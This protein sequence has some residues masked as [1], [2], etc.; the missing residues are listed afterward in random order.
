M[1]LRERYR[2]GLDP[3]LPAFSEIT[4]DWL[5]RRMTTGEAALY[6]KEFLTASAFTSEQ[7]EH[8][9]CHSLKTTFLSWAAK[10]NYLSVPDRLVMGHHMSRENQSAVAYARDE[11]TRIMVTVHQMLHDVKAHIFKPD[12]NRAERLFKAVAKE[13]GEEGG[14]GA[15]SDSDA[16]LDE[17]KL[18]KFPKQERPSWDD[19]PLEYLSRLRIH[20][21]SGV[22]HILS[23]GEARVFRCG[24]TSSKN[25]QNLSAASNFCDLPICL[26]CRPPAS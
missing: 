10:G 12:A 3:S 23:D 20:S 6:L 8:I 5:E 25:F 13:V 9:G 15:S 4:K 17:V 7:L 18:A 16:G 1:E 22:V 24:R 19:L 14:S 21:F 2:I 26:Q 11:L